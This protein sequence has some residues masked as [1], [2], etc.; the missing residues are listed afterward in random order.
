MAFR[1]LAGHCILLGA[2]SAPWHFRTIEKGDGTG[3]LEVAIQ[4]RLLPLSYEELLQVSEKTL[5]L[6]IW[7]KYPQFLKGRP[8]ESRLGPDILK[9]YF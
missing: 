7:V 2:E 3:L 6:K 4:Q 9:A 1:Y 8:E 5:L